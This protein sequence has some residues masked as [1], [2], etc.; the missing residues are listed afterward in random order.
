[1]ART[2]DDSSNHCTR[3]TDTIPTAL[4]EP[5]LPQLESH[6]CST[7]DWLFVCVL[8]A[9]AKQIRCFKGKW[10]GTGASDVGTEAQRTSDD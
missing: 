8:V 3:C 6:L 4:V 2:T 5:K 1:V 9:T 10:A 7:D